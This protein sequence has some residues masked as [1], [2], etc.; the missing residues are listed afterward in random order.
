[1]K[2]ETTIPRGF[3]RFAVLLCVA[4]GLAFAQPMVPDEA[5]GAS[6]GGPRQ[7][8]V[9]PHDPT[10]PVGAVR[11]FID[12]CRA[13]EYEAAATH[14]SLER[15]PPERRA[16]AGLTLARRLK[17]VL[18]RKLWVDYEQ[19][20]DRPEGRL[21]DRL[22]PD[23]ESIGRLE[24]TEIEILLQRAGGPADGRAWK[25]SASTVARIPALYAEHG[26]GSLGEWLP[27]PLIE[28]QF[29]ELRLWQWGGIVLLAVAAW[30]LGWV[31]VRVFNWIARPVVKRTRTALDDRVLGLV[32]SPLRLL[33]ALSCFALGSYALRLAAPAQGFLTGLEKGVAVLAMTWMAFRIV[34]VIAAL[35]QERLEAGERKA[36]L[37]A[38]PLGRRASK[39]FLVAL[40]LIGVLGNLGFDVT[41]LIAGLGV[42]G[43]ALAL[44]AQKSIENLFG[45][46]TLIAD[47]PVGVGD[48][49]RF[50]D[51]RSG[52]VE[53]IGL[54]S[55]RV[56]TLDRTLV[57]VP[58]S[59]FSEI[60][61]ENFAVRDRIRLVATLGLRY[62][63]S[64]DQLRFVLTRLREVLID[65]PRVSNDPARVRFAGFG[66][67]SLDV[68]VFA[69]VETDDFAEFTAIREDLFL[70]F[71][72][73]VA[74]A[75]TG[76][77]FPSQTLYM[78]RDEGL[79]AART[80]QAEERVAAWRAEGGP[81]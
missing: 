74:E 45:G 21:D 35:I 40:A 36:A 20:S 22:P 6:N 56:R 75:G 73:V 2:S 1:M 66:A 14:L 70:R 24:G 76:F 49:C 57:T 67:S 18:D 12:R 19:L 4:G 48:F 46:V 23:L 3:L 52:T 47:R 44:A 26:Y 37:A 17:V 54:R 71:M 9:D 55:T 51:G 28:L 8:Q 77:A 68:E 7:G 5:G 13:G 63:T 25:F 72:D 53:E 61:L 62:E 65:H 43:L 81:P 30:L 31:A 60:E 38:V 79:D 29:L 41:G 15:I 10:T 58:N 39:V 11:S 78:G 32:A 42:G 33:F 80:R 27:A 59:K 64:P 16:A 69:Y 34:D 50:G